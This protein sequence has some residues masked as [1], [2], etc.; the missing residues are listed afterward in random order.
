MHSEL[1]YLHDD[2][3]DR[4]GVR[5]KQQRVRDPSL[6]RRRKQPPN[7][8]RAPGGIRQRRNKHWTW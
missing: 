7:K 1:S 8:A 5:R 6:V 2:L 3:V 4:D